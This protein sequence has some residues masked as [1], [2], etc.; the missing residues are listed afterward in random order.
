M[1][2]ASR[3]GNMPAADLPFSRAE[4]ARRLAL[5]RTAMAER[6]IGALFV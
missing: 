4:Y 2:D 3:G 5:V 1:D 6:G